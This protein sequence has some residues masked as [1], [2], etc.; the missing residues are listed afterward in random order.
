VERR[1]FL[2]T[3]AAAVAAAVVPV[4]A[5]PDA[6]AL[7]DLWQGLTGKY[8]GALKTVVYTR[9]Y[10]G[11]KSDVTENLRRN[12]LEA[13]RPTQ[14]QIEGVYRTLEKGQWT[15]AKELAERSF[16]QRTG[17]WA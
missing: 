15:S 6:P 2:K 3:A 4:P 11:K 16:C 13:F 7:P 9:A 12:G 1:A 17:L 14:D 5:L 10:G 8:R